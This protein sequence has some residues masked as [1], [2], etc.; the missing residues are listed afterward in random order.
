MIA[1]GLAIAALARSSGAATSVLS[2]DE[3]MRRVAAYVDGYGQKASIIVCTERYTQEARGAAKQPRE[4]REIV[5]DIAIVKVAAERIWQGFRDVIEV[6]GV[7]VADRDNRLAT[8]LMASEGQYDEARRL[9]DESARFNI[10]SIRRNFNVPTATLFFFN[11]VDRRRFKFSARTVEPD[12]TWQIGF[13]ETERPTFIRTPEGR[14]IFSEGAIWVSPEHGIVTRTT[15]KVEIPT[16]GGQPGGAGAV[17]VTFHHVDAIDMWLPAAMTETFE[18]RS[19][20]DWQR[21]EG[22]ATYDNYRRFE[23]TARIK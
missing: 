2:L 18:A 8:V 20:S 21:V 14:S 1:A 12:G 13:R 9:S 7:R 19:K 22:H 10:G 6:D 3:V 11:S 17:D 23:T 16:R 4:Q 15:L 5:S